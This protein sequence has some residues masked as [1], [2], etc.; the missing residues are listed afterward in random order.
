MRAKHI[1]NYQQFIN[2]QMLDPMAAMGGA[3]GAPAPTKA[4]APLHFIFLDKSDMESYT[5]KK[6]PDG[7]L[8]V[9]FPAYSTTSADLE[10]W[11]KSNIFSD[12][13]NK[14]TDK[15]A[16]LRRKNIIDIVKGQKVNISDE[17]IPFINKLKNAVST[18][19]FGRREPEVSVFFTKDGAPT[20]EDVDVTFIEYRKNA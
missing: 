15:T 6:Y 10:D 19:I 16:E 20:T 4:E 3:P 2:E 17:D 8:E 1:L 9:G 14:L 12:G 5:K 18:D 13:T 7:S 11:A